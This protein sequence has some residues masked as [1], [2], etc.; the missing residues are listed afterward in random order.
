ML[1]LRGAGEEDRTVT[2]RLR[3]GRYRLTAAVLTGD[4]TGATLLGQPSLVLDRPSTVDMD[5]REGRPVSVTVPGES[6]R[7]VHA[8]L[9]YTGHT[10]LGR[11]FDTMYLGRVGPDVTVD[12]FATIVAGQWAKADAAG[13]VADSPYLYSLMYPTRGRAVPGY[14]RVVADRELARVRAEVAATAAGATGARRVRTAA[15]D[16]GGTF[17]PYL[18][19]R[20]PFTRT[21]FYNTDAQIASTG[22]VVE[23][24]GDGGAAWTQSETYTAY[25]TGREYREVYNTGVFGPAAATVDRSAFVGV[26]RTGDVITPWVAAFTDGALSLDLYD[27]RSL[28]DRLGVVYRDPEP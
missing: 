11:S 28:L 6:A 7:Q 15:L 22:D 24:P 25:R 27:L 21:E 23:F 1:A 14:R 26:T 13:T 18:D 17:G 19:L 4:G 16:L 20:L 8:H 2:Y 5:A 9:G 3:K 10:V 12:G